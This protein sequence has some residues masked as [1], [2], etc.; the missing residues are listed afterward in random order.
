MSVYIPESVRQFVATRADY[1][2]EYCR[3]YERYSFLAF[4]IEHIISQKHGGTSD[5]NNLAYSC[6]ICNW[7]K[8]TDVATFLEGIHVPVRF[9]NPRMDVWSNHFEVE[10]SGLI[11][12]KTNIGQATIKIFDLNHFDSMLERRYLLANNML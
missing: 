3:I 9:F 8:G 4:H 12:A 11:L 1:R 5:N 10:D 7:N 6:P 2:C